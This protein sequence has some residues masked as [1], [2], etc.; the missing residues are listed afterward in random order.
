M[1]IGV[2]GAG[3]WGTALA[4]VAARA[5]HDVCIWARRAEVVDS[6]NRNHKNPDYLSEFELSPAIRAT[7]SLAE[8]LKE[9]DLVLVV[10]PS[11]QIRRTAENLADEGIGDQVPIVVCTKGVE[12]DSGLVPIQILEEIIGNPQRLAC[13]SGPNHAEEVIQG[14]PSGTVVAS[15]N[16]ECAVFVQQALGAPEFRIYTS[17]DTIG[18]ELCAAAKNVVAIAVGLS[19]GLGYGDNTA[20]MLMTR[21]QAEMSRLVEACGGSALTCMGLAGTGDLIATCMSQHSRNRTFGEALAA[22]ETLEEYESRRHMVVEGAQACRS[23]GALSERLGV[24]LPL[25]QAV[26]AII[27]ENVDPRA[28]S[29][30]LTSREQKP[31]FY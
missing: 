19:Y 16:A 15:N 31:E 1:R 24:E 14:L 20:A 8:S 5:G 25:A 3:S 18:V 21:G 12:G 7:T 2:I 10:T 23:I 11:I 26:N 28:M 29:N 6:I 30:E 22:G 17:T 9:A 4:Q 13:L 27:W